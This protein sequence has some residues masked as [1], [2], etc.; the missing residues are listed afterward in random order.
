MFD[1]VVLVHPNIS[2]TCLYFMPCMTAARIRSTASTGI[3][4]PL[5]ATASPSLRGFHHLVPD[6]LPVHGERPVRLVA[7]GAQT[8]NH[9]CGLVCRVRF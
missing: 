6:E 2:D 8:L 9:V 4:V 7:L 1:T 5:S 3:G